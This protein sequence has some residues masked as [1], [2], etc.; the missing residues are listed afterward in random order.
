METPA[1]WAGPP[2]C[3]PRCCT[4]C[5][6]GAGWQADPRVKGSGE[7]G[8][9]LGM[10]LYL[11]RRWYRPL[12]VAGEPLDTAWRVAP[13]WEEFSPHATLPPRCHLFQEVCPGLPGW[14]G[15]LPCSWPSIAGVP[16]SVSGRP[17]SLEAGDSVR[18]LTLY[19]GLCTGLGVG[20]RQ[21]RQAGCPRMLVGRGEGE[22][23]RSC[24]TALGGHARV[25][26]AW[27]S[28]KLFPPH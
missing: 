14:A 12:C 8:A 20:G 17:L 16:S 1:G 18:D 11:G 9:G 13:Q 22:N 3:T 23:E 7:A 24:L 10:W 27:A 28:R 21:R 25:E 2:G 6:Q 26:R 4:P 15:L 5:G 19:P